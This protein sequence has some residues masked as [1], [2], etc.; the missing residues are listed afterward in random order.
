MKRILMPLII[1]MLGAGLFANP[2]VP[3]LIARV[4][5]SSS[6]NF[7]VYFGDEMAML[8]DYST[9]YFSTSYGN[10][11]VPDGFSFPSLP[12]FVA[13]NQ[14][15]PAFQIDRDE[16]FFTA[17]MGAW[18]ETIAWGPQNDTSVN[19]HSIPD[20]MSAVQTRVDGMYGQYN[21]WALT[22]TSMSS[23][24]YDVSSTFTIDVQV[25]E[26][27]GSPAPLVPVFLSYDEWQ[28]TDYTT[29][30]TDSEGLCH[31]ISVPARV[32]VIVLDPFDGAHALDSLIFPLP[33]E[34][35]DLEAVFCHVANNDP[36]T[37]ASV[38]RLWPSV[39][40]SRSGN[41]LKLRS[42]GLG[43]EAGLRLYDLRGRYLCSQTMPSSGELDWQ[44]PELDSGI[45][46]VRLELGDRLLGSARFTVLK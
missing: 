28:N 18:V 20:G 32:R 3:R 22:P 9:L 14:I 10:F 17:H 33:N 2:V 16:D 37:A 34:H 13:M 6:G 40:S 43:R 19:M 45:Y 7:S 46:F 27:D 12:Y 25:S 8:M 23:L 38:L 1:L 4:W 35:Y 39:I 5:W 42:E 26:F 15:I 24:P 29:H 41:I 11:R 30:F 36:V 31:I 44:L 21:V